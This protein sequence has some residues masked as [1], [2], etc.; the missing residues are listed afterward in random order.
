V[1]PKQDGST[2]AGNIIGG[3]GTPQGAPQLLLTGEDAPGVFAIESNQIIG[4]A[5]PGVVITSAAPLRGTIRCNSFERGTIGLQLSTQR[6][7]LN[8]FELAIDTNSFIGQARFGAA[9]TLAFNVANNW[10][11]DPSGPLEP[12][13]NPQG[14]GVPIGVNLQF[15]PWLL[16]RPG[17]APR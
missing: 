7:A 4:E 17:C 8:G 3:N 10:W 2:I 9:G 15:Q 16:E 11:G 1:L 5:G 6:P 14:R 13:R 12:Q